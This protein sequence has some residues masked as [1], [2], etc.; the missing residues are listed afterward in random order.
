[1][2]VRWDREDRSRRVNQ[3]FDFGLVA[4]VSLRCLFDIQGEM[5]QGKL[6]YGVGN[7]NLGVTSTGLAFI[8]IG[9]NEINHPRNK[10]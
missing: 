7:R 8:A 3:G 9:L 4:T 10:T 1:M 2:A 6:E 5:L